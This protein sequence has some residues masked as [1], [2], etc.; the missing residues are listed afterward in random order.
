MP[1][2]PPG[3]PNSGTATPV[4]VLV[5]TPTPSVSATVRIQNTGTGT[6]YVGGASVSPVNGFAILPSNR[7]VELQNVTAN[8]YL[9]SGYI[10]ATGTVLTS[11]T[12]V[13]N[14]A[15]GFTVASGGTVPTGY[16]RLGNGTSLEFLNNTAATGSVATT[17]TPTLYD[18][19]VSST[20]A[21]I[22]AAATGYVVVAGVI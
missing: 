20:V 2:F 10:N 11:A 18:H 9:C 16:I 14:G 21:S 22:T 12:A 3:T 17:T 1:T 4:P 19:G 7:P 13:T 6:L 15:T 8:V 5:F